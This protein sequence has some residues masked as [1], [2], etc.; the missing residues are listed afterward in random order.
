MKHQYKTEIFW[1]KSL[2][3]FIDF[4]VDI[5]AKFFIRRKINIQYTEPK[6][7]LFVTLAQLGD[8]LAES[9]VFPLIKERFPN[10]DIDVITSEWCKPILKNNPYIRNVFFFNHF[11]MNRSEKSFLKK[12][13][14]HI[15]SSRASLKKIRLQKYDLSIEGGVTYPNGNLL[16]YRGKVERRIGTGSGG[17]GALLTDIAEIP[18]HHGFHILEALLEVLR[19]IGIKKKLEDLKPYYIIHNKKAFIKHPFSSYFNRSFIIIHPESGNVKRTMSN[20]FW[21]E[22]IKIIFNTTNFYVIICG[23]SIKS[24]ELINFCLANLHKGKDYITN[25]VQ[26]LS[27]DELFLLSKYAK[28][29]FTVES[30]AA[31]FCA[32]NC[33]TFSFFK[34]GSGAYFFPIPN[35]KSTIIH[36]HFPSKNIKVHHNLENYFVE[37]IESDEIF[38]L[39]NKFIL[40]LVN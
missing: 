30:F 31:H 38:E 7:I 34:N 1:K 3:L 19:L 16:C 8:A 20:D 36:N 28:A 32:I 13:S 11:R 40:G 18:P 29:A 14:S 5:Y 39:V 26:K 6:N 2:H 25:A 10:A 4:F 37:N 9:Y 23:T 24:I 27:I 21:L 22:I 33:N 15:K 35:K 17:F 12:I